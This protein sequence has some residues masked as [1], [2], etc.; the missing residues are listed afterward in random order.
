ML[1]EL[2]HNEAVVNQIVNGT[3]WQDKIGCVLYDTE[4]GRSIAQGS[5]L[6]LPEEIRK[7]ISTAYA[8]VG[9]STL[10]YPLYDTRPEGNAFAEAK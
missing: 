7:L 5:L 10:C 4:Y 9:E 1:L 3:S 6:L 8:E 2:E